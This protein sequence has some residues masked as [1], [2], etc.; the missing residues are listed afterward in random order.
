MSNDPDSYK[1]SYVKKGKPAH[2]IKVHEKK[3]TGNGKEELTK[4]ENGVR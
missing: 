4:V 3:Y 2:T 1:L